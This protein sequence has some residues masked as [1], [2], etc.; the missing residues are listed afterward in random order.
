M[1]RAFH[2]L[3]VALILALAVGLAAA[4][5]RADEK[6]PLFGWNSEEFSLF[7][8]IYIGHG[9]FSIPCI[10]LTEDSFSIP[11]IHYESKPETRF[12]LTPVY[13]WDPAA[14]STTRGSRGWRTGHSI[15]SR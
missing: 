4:P 3:T 8:L 7:P 9:G 14:R 10:R 15:S 2:A 11:F 6:T 5:A 1:R 12:D 13:H